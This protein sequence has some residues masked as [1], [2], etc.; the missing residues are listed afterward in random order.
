VNPFIQKLQ[1]RVGRFP[2]ELPAA[3]AMALAV[4]FVTVTLPDWRFERAV[5]ATGLANVFSAAAPPLG[6]TARIV[7][8]L[9][10]AVAAF[11]AVRYGLRAL[12]RKPQESDFPAFRAADLHPDAPRRRPILAGAEFGKV[13]EEAPPARKRALV[14]EPMPSFLAPQPAE[15]GDF[16]PEPAVPEPAVP[17]PAVDELAKPPIKVQVLPRET[18]AAEAPVPEAR[19]PEAR[20]PEAPVLEA[21]G[22]ETRTPEAP[23]P[24]RAESDAFFEDFGPVVAPATAEPF[25]IPREPANDRASKPAPDAV[26]DDD[27]MDNDAGDEVPA[28]MR[29]SAPEPRKMEAPR[30]ADPFFDAPEPVA[31]GVRQENDDREES[32]TELMARLEGGLARREG[33]PPPTGSA[34]FAQEE[35][36][37]AIKDLDRAVGGNGRG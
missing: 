11:L 6:L 36:E 5:A 18:P 28:F 3:A 22:P 24:P 37:R 20:V 29:S 27:A 35:L 16:V 23:V 30:A 19:A 1:R 15:I 21:P 32:V 34:Y 25:G 17:E 26:V 2:I 31:D 7:A 14:S 9:G 8:A 13:A 12:D 4:A 33:K 10:L